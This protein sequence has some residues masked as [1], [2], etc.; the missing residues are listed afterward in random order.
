MPN[1]YTTTLIKYGGYYWHKAMIWPCSMAL[2][3]QGR[4]WGQSYQVESGFQA[5]T[6]SM[7]YLSFI[8]FIASNIPS[9]QSL[10]DSSGLEGL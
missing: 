7:Q 4:V 10:L 3:V 5:F 6:A 1:T 2:R 8:M 9:S